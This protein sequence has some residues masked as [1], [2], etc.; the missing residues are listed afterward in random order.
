MRGSAKVILVLEKHLP[1][2]VKN[3]GYHQENLSDELMFEMDI[4]QE[5]DCIH[6]FFD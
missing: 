1:T 5:M 6:I 2:T 3:I 4:F